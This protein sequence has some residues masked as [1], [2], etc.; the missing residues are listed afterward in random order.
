MS[1]KFVRFVAALVVV[2][3]IVGNSGVALAER[4][5]AR[6]GAARRTS[7]RR[8]GQWITFHKK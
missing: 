1:T 7:N 2:V 8:A 6:R 4:G 5:A 3:S